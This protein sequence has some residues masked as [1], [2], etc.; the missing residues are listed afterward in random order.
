MG[1]GYGGGDLMG[2]EVGKGDNIAPSSG[3]QQAL[4]ACLVLLIK[5]LRNLYRA[6]LPIS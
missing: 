1:A 4:P 3:L 6:L 2:Q 5:P